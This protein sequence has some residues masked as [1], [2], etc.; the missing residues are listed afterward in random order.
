LFPYLSA[1]HTCEDFNTGTWIP[2]T[3]YI[4]L[5][6]YYASFAKIEKLIATIITSHDAAILHCKRYPSS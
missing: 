5:E 3:T 6:S 4:D 2:S 1:C